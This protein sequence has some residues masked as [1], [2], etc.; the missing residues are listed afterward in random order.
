[1]IIL[2]KSKEINDLKAK[3]GY[4]EN[5]ICEL[6]KSLDK[7]IQIWKKRDMLILSD[8]KGR[9]CEEQLLSYLQKCTF[10]KQKDN[11]YLGRCYEL[12]VDY[13]ERT[14]DEVVEQ[15]KNHDIRNMDSLIYEI[16][17]LEQLQDTLEWIR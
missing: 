12:S 17:K 3:V 5:E 15:I 6:E 4:L 9:L 14:Y 7:R 10:N 16:E 8:F 11:R 1:M 2:R 13:E